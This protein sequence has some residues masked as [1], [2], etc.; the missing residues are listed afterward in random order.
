MKFIL[1]AIIL[2]F[3]VLSYSQDYKL[4]H[5]DS[6]KVYTNFPVPDSSFSI[7]FDSV[8]RVGSDS[9]YYNYT[10]T[11]NIITSDSC[12]FWGAPECTKQ[13]RPTWL[14]AGIKF[15]NES[16]YTF[17]TNDGESLNFDFSSTGGNPVLFY[18]NATDKF[19][20]TF[21]KSDTMSILGFVD[22]TRFFTI[23]HTDVSGNTINS[24]LNGSH[25]SIA[26][27]LGLV[28]FFQV[29]AFPDVL[30]PVYM[31]GNITPDLGLD[32]ITN[33]DI[34]NYEIGD[35]FQI[36]ETTYYHY[37]P[38]NQNSDRFT[39]YFIIG[40][41]ITAD[42]VIYTAESEVF[43][44]GSSSAS[45]DIVFLKYKSNEVIAQIPYEYT[46]PAQYFYNIHSLRS[47]NYCGTK[48]WTYRVKPNQGLRYCDI[49]NC[50]GPNDVPGPAPTQEDVYTLGLGLYYSI[51]SE[52]IINWNSPGYHHTS[53]LIYSRKNEV[54]CGAEAFLGISEKPLVSDLFSVYPVPARDFITVETEQPIG[55]WLSIHTI[56]G[57]EINKQ[58]LFETKTQIDISHLKSGIYMLKLI[59]GKS[60]MIK[61]MVRE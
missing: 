43:E 54:E 16:N 51:Y 38:P 21:V 52:G 39:R 11:G 34:Y 7:A 61:M 9:V 20:Y 57:T 45:N 33:A 47:E 40:K 15:D 49:D 3:S 1:T 24:P 4:F 48:R 46:N 14:G 32:K 22:S 12:R 50:W 36:H 31:L 8:L 59:T 23:T 41:L 35:E 58:Q 5:A 26:K 55:S 18:Q 53:E 13:D 60:V 28:Q 44:K 6:R 30:N 17:F 2:L 27:T 29:D 37:S 10:Q 19:S 42:S 25:I 56:S